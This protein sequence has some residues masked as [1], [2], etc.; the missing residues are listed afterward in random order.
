[1]LN[2]NVTRLLSELTW[3]HNGA[4][5]VP[6]QDE[7]I[8]LSNDNKT[9]TVNN[10]T[11]ADAGV[12]RAQFNRISVEPYNQSCNDKLI[13]LLRNY[14]IFAPAIYCIGVNSCTYNDSMS[15]LR[16]S[17]QRLK[18]MNMSDAGGL[19]L[20][21]VGIAGTISREEF[22]HIS[23][24]WYVNRVSLSRSVE[25]EWRQYPTIG[26]RLTIT[27]PDSE[28]PYG[29]TGRYEI[30]L[31]V[32]LNEYLGDPHS[33]CQALYNS[34]LLVPYRRYSNIYHTSTYSLP[35]SWGFID[36]IYNGKHLPM[37]FRA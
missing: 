17:V 33:T 32:N 31:T 22:E 3:Y 18:F 8:I 35:L 21:T 15:L 4:V 27:D 30:A 13:P 36:V 37:P 23:L 24:R 25:Y 34:H 7:R 29:F 20:E 5:I 1:M 14:P 26:Q 19:S 2:I 16:V 12:Y 9:L 10:F 6:D 28:V 11:S